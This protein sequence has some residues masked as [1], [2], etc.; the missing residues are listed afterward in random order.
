M[1][2]V[3]AGQQYQAGESGVVMT[4]GQWESL[5]GHTWKL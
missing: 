5:Q 3:G 2:G 1:E 4:H